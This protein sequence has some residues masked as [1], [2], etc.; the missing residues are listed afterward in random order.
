MKMGQTEWDPLTLAIQ[1]TVPLKTIIYTK[2]ILLPVP[3]GEVTSSNCFV[4]FFPLEEIVYVIILSNCLF[5]S[6]QTSAEL[7]KKS[8]TAK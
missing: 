5:F 4:P 7:I 2:Q 1:A 3:Q 6:L 8:L